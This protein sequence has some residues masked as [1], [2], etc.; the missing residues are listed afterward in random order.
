MHK[1]SGSIIT[2][3]HFFAFVK[4]KWNRDLLRWK[5]IWLSTLHYLRDLLFSKK[6]L[7]KLL[8]ARLQSKVSASG[9]FDRSLDGGC[10]LSVSSLVAKQ[11]TFIQDQHRK[12]GNIGQPSCLFIQNVYRTEWYQIK[13]YYEN[14]EL[15]FTIISSSNI[16][17][18]LNSLL[19]VTHDVTVKNLTSV[20]TCTA[21]DQGAFLSNKQANNDNKLSCANNYEPN[22]IRSM[23]TI[24]LNQVDKVKKNLDIVN[25]RH[26]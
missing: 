19:N 6:F 14:F 15:K 8:K 2:F 9:S 1:Q 23:Q 18:K 21:F 20:I 22:K 17:N 24:N 12:L 3:V 16:I 5:E 4:H 11:N 25:D 13:N 26:I 10:S 7:I